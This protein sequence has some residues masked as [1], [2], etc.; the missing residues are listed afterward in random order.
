[1]AK[2]TIADIENTLT[3]TGWDKDR[4]GNFKSP[5]GKYRVKIQKTSLRVEQKI[6]FSAS[7]YDDSM[8]TQWSN[9]TSDYICNIKIEAG[10]I[11]IKNRKL[12]KFGDK[13]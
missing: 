5:T 10:R 11:I 4:F 7:A 9:V 13:V 12:Q 1:M 3:N 2:L 8:K 6:E